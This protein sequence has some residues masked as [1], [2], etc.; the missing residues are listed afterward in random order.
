MGLYTEKKKGEGSRKICVHSGGKFK[1]FYCKPKGQWIVGVDVASGE[2]W[3]F[4]E[5]SART[6]DQVVG[7]WSFWDSRQE[8]WVK[9]ADLRVVS[10]NG[11]RKESDIPLMDLSDR[12]SN[13]KVKD[14]QPQPN[15][16]QSNPYDPN[17]LSMDNF[18]TL[19]VIGRGSFGEVRVCSKKGT[20]EVFAIKKLRKREM[21]KR[22]Q[23][24]HIWGERRFLAGADNPWVVR[25]FHSFQDRRNLYFVLEYCPGGDLLRLL[26]QKDKF[27]EKDTAF[28]I[29]ELACAV[30]S[31]HDMGYIHRD[32]KPDNILVS[33]TGHLKLTDFG[34]CKQLAQD[35][36]QKLWE[37][38][39]K[40]DK[41][42]GNKKVGGSYRRKQQSCVGTPDY[43]APEVLR[44][45]YGR[46]CDWWSVGVIL[47]EC[48]Y[49]YPP[50][51][52]DSLQETAH[53]ILKFK[54][55]LKIP[56]TPKHS[57]RAI[58][59]INK[60]LTTKE[61]RITFHELCKHPFFGH[62][63]WKN[64]DKMEPPYVPEVKHK[65]DTANFDKFESVRGKSIR[66]IK[67]DTQRLNFPEFTW[68]RRQTPNKRADVFGPSF[69]DDENME[70]NPIANPISKE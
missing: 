32:I 16:Q 18:N 9:E 58:S 59:I 53:R 7:G 46:E 34:L 52:T 2:G 19:R 45:R 14:Q 5:S 3:L 43:V 44:R 20:G 49:G 38:V 62:I 12:M 11:R 17:K 23:V 21:L 39:E 48:L 25:L 10:A 54:E 55:F 26:I 30:H 69:F 65:L 51:M 31:V 67:G 27:S 61:E 63:D 41:T 8:D 64:L 60:M 33:A 70:N 42:A 57:S 1:M 13:L 28:Y 29:A 24:Q 56:K 47:F 22:N 4:V 35:A 36:D 40:L 50:F 6:P 15:K 66:S 37:N 68:D